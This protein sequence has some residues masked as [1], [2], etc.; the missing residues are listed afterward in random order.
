MNFSNF[1]SIF[2]TV[3]GTNKTRPNYLLEI[4]ENFID[5]S[6]ELPNPLE[7][8]E[9]NTLNKIFN[10][11]LNLSRSTAK[12]L[13]LMINKNKFI[14][15]LS[16]FNDYQIDIIINEFSNY[17]IYINPFESYESLADIFENILINVSMGNPNS[18]YLFKNTNY[19]YNLLIN[20]EHMFF[21][22][23]ELFYENKVIGSID[24]S[25]ICNNNTL[26]MKQLISI[27][28][29]MLDV[30]HYDISNI[31]ELPSEYLQQLKNYQHHFFFE[32]N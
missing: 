16:T 6:N 22:E 24:K 27:Y 17:N 12:R 9:L 2:F 10:G 14:D 21:L 5:T 3:S 1:L 4:I 7:R 18:T 30:K 25:I 15:Y 13:T 20:K 29:E 19:S 11:T 8:Y 32:K 28:N 23:N 26:F 31:D